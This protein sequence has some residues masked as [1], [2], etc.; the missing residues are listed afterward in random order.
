M[1]EKVIGIL[2]N[3][4]E[5]IVATLVE[6]TDSVIKVKN[7]AFLGIS[8]QNNQININFI[9]LEML[10]LQPSVNVRNLLA[11]QTEELIYTFDKNSL[12]HSG[13]DLA[14]NVIDNYKNLTNGKSDAP[15]QTPVSNKSAEDNIIKLF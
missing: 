6:E 3:V 9:P 5:L 2:K 10:S 15:S 12:L 4:S 14:Q 7:P 11:N 1:E 8:G 13:L